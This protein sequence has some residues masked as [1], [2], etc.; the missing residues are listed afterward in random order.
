MAEPGSKPRKADSGTL[1][2]SHHLLPS[3]SPALPNPD[4]WPPRFPS[5]LCSHLPDLPS[6]LKPG[7]LPV[8]LSPIVVFV[9][10]G[11]LDVQDAPAN[12][13]QHVQV[14][15]EDVL[16][17]QQVPCYLGPLGARE[18]GKGTLLAIFPAGK[19][20]LTVTYLQRSQREASRPPF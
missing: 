18:A 1:S 14:F 12:S 4:L 11:V 13:S 6:L 20:E 9:P 16:N 15:V 19:M 7:G 8:M 3:T 10:R 2:L 17:L 5:T